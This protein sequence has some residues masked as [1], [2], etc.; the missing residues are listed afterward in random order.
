MI[1]GIGVDTV[2]LE[3]IRHSVD[4]FGSRFVQRI[5]NPEEQ[6]IYRQHSRA[7][8]FLAKRFAAKEAMVKALGVGFRHGLS[9]QDI[10]IR[11]DSLG[12]P[13][14][15]LSGQAKTIAE[16]KDIRHCH[17]SLSDEKDSAIAFVI[18]E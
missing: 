14:I 1:K 2:R 8:S 16:K 5:L 15:V 17:L 4:R 9:W 6:S 18:A 7:I 12:K 13:F 10:S 11:S 3:R